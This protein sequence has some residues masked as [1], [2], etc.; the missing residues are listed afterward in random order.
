M[1]H[2]KIFGSLLFFGFLLSCSTGDVSTDNV[3]ENLDDSSSS[4]ESSSSVSSSSSYD[5]DLQGGCSV[6]LSK[7]TL[8]FNGQGGVDT[9]DIG[10]AKFYDPIYCRETT[11][12]C[13]YIRSDYNVYVTGTGI[14]R[15]ETDYCKNNYCINMP[16][17]YYPLYD[18]GK[19]CYSS[20]TKI[21]CPWYSMAFIYGNTL[22]VSVNKNE[23]GEERSFREILDAINCDYLGI[24]V[25][26]SA[27]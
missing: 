25:I 23:T 14:V 22:Q 13:T 7:D 18:E 24:T 4:T 5:G 11:N 9:I 27:E 6:K 8:Y 20:I 17:E 3:G 26:Q 1:K 21:E 2:T 10:W 16:D 15:I 19:L 12:T